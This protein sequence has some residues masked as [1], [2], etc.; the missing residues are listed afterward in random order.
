MQSPTPS[1]SQPYRQPS[2]NYGGYRRYWSIKNCI[3][4]SFTRRV[5]DQ[6]LIAQDSAGVCIQQIWVHLIFIVVGPVV[7][8]LFSRSNLVT[9]YSHACRK[10]SPRTHSSWIRRVD[11]LLAQCSFPESQLRDVRQIWAFADT[12]I[13]RPLCDFSGKAC[14]NFP[15]PTESN[16]DE[17]SLEVICL[18]V[19]KNECQ[20]HDRIQ[21]HDTEQSTD[22]EWIVSFFDCAWEA[23]NPKLAVWVLKTEPAD[24][25]HPQIP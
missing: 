3:Y 8:H 7:A 11:S 21:T 2:Y 23:G 12:D 22:Y 16:S 9:S 5:L 25:D 24:V 15:E 13:I 1:Y 20:N 4:S 17:I 18:D 14:L 6:A 10:E 19:S